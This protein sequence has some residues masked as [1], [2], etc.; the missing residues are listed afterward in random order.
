MNTPQSEKLGE[1]LAKIHQSAS[2]FK[3]QFYRPVLSLE[4]LLDNSF[5]IIAPFLEHRQADLSYV[6]DLIPYI[7]NQLKHFPKKTPYWSVCW[8]DPHSGNAHFTE[9]GEVTLFDFD[10]CGY[11]WRVF[12]FGKF[13]QVSLRTGISKKVRDAFLTGYQSVYPLTED[14]L[15][16]LQPMTQMAQIW[17]WSIN[18]N[19]YKVFNY[20]KIDDSYLTHRLEQLKRLKSK[21]WQLF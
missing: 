7:K 10:Q 15:N 4:Y 12:D 19:R 21:D 20:S 2:E 17:A 14:E 8:G 1:A 9:S 3:S 13:L 5:A 16:V 18:I 6:S 11:G